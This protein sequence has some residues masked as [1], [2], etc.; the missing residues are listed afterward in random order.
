MDTQRFPCRNS[1]LLI[2]KIS[3]N[4]KIL[5]PNHYSDTFMVQNEFI[6][7]NL[8]LRIEI[9]EIRQKSV[10]ITVKNHEKY[11]KTTFFQQKLEINHKLLTFSER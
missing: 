7:H 4:H 6:F 10:V 8:H 3:F 2:K 9:C 11:V 5:T 1:L